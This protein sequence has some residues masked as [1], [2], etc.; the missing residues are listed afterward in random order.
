MTK[1]RPKLTHEE[2]TQIA[3]TLNRHPRVREVVQRV[4]SFGY[5]VVIVKTKGGGY[6]SIATHEDH[7][8]LMEHLARLM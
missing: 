5:P 2:F 3:R 7:L 6:F 4:S 8:A 1:T